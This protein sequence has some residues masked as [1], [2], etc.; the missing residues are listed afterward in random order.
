[1]CALGPPFPFGAAGHAPCHVPSRLFRQPV[2]GSGRC[3]E[4]RLSRPL[5]I[6]GTDA[7]RPL[8]AGRRLVEDKGK[9]L[10]QPANYLECRMR[11][12]MSEA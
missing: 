5:D 2:P 12:S 7:R 8:S 1:M 4:V 9:F 3:L 10:V 6:R 11:C